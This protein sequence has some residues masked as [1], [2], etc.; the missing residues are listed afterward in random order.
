MLKEKHESGEAIMEVTVTEMEKMDKWY[1][2]NLRGF[3]MQAK[4]LG[5]ALDRE[6]Y[7]TAKEILNELTAD[8]EFAM[9]DRGED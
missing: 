5:D 4:Q 6:L 2:T 7:T 9:E 3:L 1:R 8:L